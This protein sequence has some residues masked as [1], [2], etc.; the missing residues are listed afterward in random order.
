MLCYPRCSLRIQVAIATQNIAKNLLP[1]A[2]LCTPFLF[3]KWSLIC[4]H[5]ITRF[6]SFC[7]TLSGLT[8]ERRGG[9]PLEGAVQGGKGAGR[10]ASTR[11]MAVREPSREAMMRCR[12]RG[13]R[14]GRRRGC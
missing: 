12:D 2:S 7:D 9:H 14:A 4:C 5:H 10:E 6:D 13:R 3:T 8:G 11:C 1:E